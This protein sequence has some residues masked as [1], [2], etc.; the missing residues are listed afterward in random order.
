MYIFQFYMP[1]LFEYIGEQDT[2]I[3]RFTNWKNRYRDRT[4]HVIVKNVPV[5][6]LQ[7]LNF[8]KLVGDDP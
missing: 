4:T 7:H 8:Y 6:V 1:G 3:H 2:T 5:V